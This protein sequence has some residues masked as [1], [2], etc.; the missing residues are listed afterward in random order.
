MNVVLLAGRGESTCPVGNVL[1]NR[2]GLRAIILEPVGK[3]QML[4]RGA[5]N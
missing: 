2:I 5:K 1:H 4:K 3:I